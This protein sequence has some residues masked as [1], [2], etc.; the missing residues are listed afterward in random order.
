MA[1]T[2]ESLTAPAD[3]TMN[4]EQMRKTLADVRRRMEKALR[5][6]AK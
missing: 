2:K 6:G 3:E 4:V 1:E 5:D